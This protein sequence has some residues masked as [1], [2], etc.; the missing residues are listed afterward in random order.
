MKIRKA[1]ASVLTT[2]LVV[3]ANFPA[4]DAAGRSTNAPINTILNGK[5]APKAS[6]GIDGDFYI[7]TRSL[8]FYGPKIKGRW[9]SPKSIQGP[10]G[11]AGSDGKSQSSKG[12]GT[13]NVS[14]VVGPQGPQGVQG[15]QGAVGPQ[16]E[17]GEKGEKG[18]PGAPGS[19]GP[20]GPP[21]SAGANGASGPQGQQGPQGVAGPTGSTGAKGETG[22]AGPSEVTVIDIPSWTLSTSTPLSFSASDSVGNLLSGNSYKFDVHIFGQSQLNNLVLGIDV[23]SANA[24]VNF[25]AI[26]SDSRY[27]TYSS[28]VYRYGFVVSGTIS[29]ILGSTGLSFRVIDG[30]GE[31]GV[32][33]LTL[34]GKAYITLVG[35][36]K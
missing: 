32:N 14:T 30:Y 1:L 33:S 31:T 20:A 4:A 9:P 36:V 34:T 21:G 15:I 17:R 11:P 6:L 35:A 7:D 28:T 8:L 18:D 19:P 2:A 16:G 25:S 29:G 3:S 24:T 22:T 13:A 27:S 23:V 26:R 12:V 5:G 10:T